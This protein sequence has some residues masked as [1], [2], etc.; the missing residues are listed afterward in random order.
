MQHAHQQWGSAAPAIA[1]HAAAWLRAVHSSAQ[2]APLRD[3]PLTAAHVRQLRHLQLGATAPHDATFLHGRRQRLQAVDADLE[4]K[5]ERSLARL[6]GQALAEACQHV[7]TADSRPLDAPQASRASRS[8][9]PR[10][11][12][13]GRGV[14]SPNRAMVV[15]KNRVKLCKIVLARMLQRRLNGGSTARAGSRRVRAPACDCHAPCVATALRRPWTWL[16]THGIQASASTADH[17]CQ[18]LCNV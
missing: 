18:V 14:F 12:G 17:C 9:L 10:R 1:V 3:P 11:E 6:G 8:E 7:L 13:A 16:R 15:S 4:A 5:L 2:R